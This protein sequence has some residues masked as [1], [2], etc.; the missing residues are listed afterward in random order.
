[1]GGDWSGRA[2][3]DGA[4]VP[5]ELN[6]SYP[7][8]L[9]DAPDTP[10]PVLARRLLA[11]ASI[12]FALQG[13]PGVYIHS[14]LGSRS[15]RD[16]PSATGEKRSINRER[17]ELG[18]LR[19]EI[20]DSDGIRATAVA[21]HRRLLRARRDHPVFDP[22]VPHSVQP[23]DPRVFSVVRRGEHDALWCVT[24]VSGADVT[25]DPL[26]DW[27]QRHDVLSG[28]DEVGPVHLGPHQYRWFRRVSR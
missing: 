28:L 9:A 16:G 23:V 19:T 1:M 15:W 20:A 13:V 22:Y 27:G 24:S 26:E 14:H 8:I 10:E 5:Y 4:V 7:D 12:Q 11:A 21:G 17:L 25:V 2:T 18:R 6:I 3:S